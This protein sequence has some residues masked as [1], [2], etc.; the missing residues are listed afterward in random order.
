MGSMKVRLLG[1]AMAFTA[2]AGCGD[3]GSSATSVTP[4]STTAVSDAETSTTTT[5]TT[6][7]T[8]TIATGLIPSDL[9]CDAA[10]A[11]GV[12]LPLEGNGV[13]IAP[14]GV[15]G[16]TL[17]VVNV[18]ANDPDGG[19]LVWTG[20][21]APGS[22]VPQEG[23]YQVVTVIPPAADGVQVTGHATSD[24]LW[25]FVVWQ[26]VAGWARSAFLG[27][28]G[29]IPP[30]PPPPACPGSGVGAVPGSAVNIS[31]LTGDFDGDGDTDDFSVYEESGLYYAHFVID[32]ASNGDYGARIT[33]GSPP[34]PYAPTAGS[35]A[36]LPSVTD[37]NNDGVDEAWMHGPWTA[38]HE[39]TSMVVFNEFNCQPYHATH[40]DGTW[41][42]SAGDPVGWPKGATVNYSYD[43][44]FAPN[45]NGTWSLIEVRDEPPSPFL[46]FEHS[47]SHSPTTGQVAEFY[48]VGPSSLTC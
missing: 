32:N 17:S 5:T 33:V 21:G 31:S 27:V 18:P 6:S 39:V 16:G 3:D 9:A 11:V 35:L 2:V 8:T 40:H 15:A 44:C 25:Y 20:P 23:K 29:A 28:P 36:S 30:P 4:T 45:A 24:G 37:L 46:V 42:N 47:F 1:L 22:K 41:S 43:I 19:L 10:G 12:W 34:Y 38:S 13:C 48:V 7:S 14:G 26:G